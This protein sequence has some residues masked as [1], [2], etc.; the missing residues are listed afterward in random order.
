MCLDSFDCDDQFVGDLGVRGAKDQ[1]LEHFAFTFRKR[2]CQ[3]RIRRDGR[4][5][6]IVAWFDIKAD[7]RCRDAVRLF[8]QPRCRAGDRGPLLVHPFGIQH[9]FVKQ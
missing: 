6:D 8:G 3:P 9:P 7:R 2:R 1:S 4:R 5:L